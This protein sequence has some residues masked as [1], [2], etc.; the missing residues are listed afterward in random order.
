[1]GHVACVV[2]RS[3]IAGVWDCELVH[4]IRQRNILRN[5]GCKFGALV[6]RPQAHRAYFFLELDA[7]PADTRRDGSFSVFDWLHLYRAVEQRQFAGVGVTDHDLN[8]LR[9]YGSRDGDD[10][11][12]GGSYGAGRDSAIATHSRSLQCTALTR[13]AHH[14]FQPSL[15]CVGS[16]APCLRGRCARSFPKNALGKCSRHCVCSRCRRRN[17]DAYSSST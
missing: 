6:P 13:C 4:F 7:K 14:N 17:W 1:M 16:R 3:G 2:P 15:S 12:V 10:S 11:R 9:R 8:V 5:G